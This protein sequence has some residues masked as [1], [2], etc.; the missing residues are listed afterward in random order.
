MPISGHNINTE[1]LT[2]IV[3]FVYDM[4][5]HSI[6]VAGFGR[7][8]SNTQSPTLTLINNMLRRFA[9]YSGN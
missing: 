7:E 4:S 6:Q 3:P 2:L 8:N 9:E 5:S 1:P